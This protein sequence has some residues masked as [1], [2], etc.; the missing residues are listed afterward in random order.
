MFGIPAG[1]LRKYPWIWRLSGAQLCICLK[2][3]GHPEIVSP[4][5]L[6]PSDQLDM[7]WFCEI[8]VSSIERNEPIIDNA[9]PLG[10][11]DRE[12]ND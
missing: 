2:P 11:P 6:E 9:A 4:K 12:K 3:R 5:A 10:K 7:D 8:F 1:R